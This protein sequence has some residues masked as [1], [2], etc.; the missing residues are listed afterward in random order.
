MY[1]TKHVSVHLEE[2]RETGWVGLGGGQ[3]RSSDDQDEND[4]TRMKS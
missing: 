1:S 2:A 4:R 3:P